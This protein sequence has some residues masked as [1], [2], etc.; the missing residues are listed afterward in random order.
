M[1]EIGS[2]AKSGAGGWKLLCQL[3][4]HRKVAAMGWGPYTRDEKEVVGGE[5][6]DGELAP[7]SSVGREGSFFG[8]FQHSELC[9]VAGA[10]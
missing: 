8:M 7:V 2:A 1:D 3:R 10:V 9:G 4:Q 6:V 5:E